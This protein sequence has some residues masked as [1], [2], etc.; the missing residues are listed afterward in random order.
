MRWR[1]WPRTQKGWGILGIWCAL[2]LWKGLIAKDGARTGSFAGDL[3]ASL[4]AIGIVYLLI[5]ACESLYF[6]VRAR[7]RG[8]DPGIRP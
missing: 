3:L 5:L 6:I 8:G 2:C 4:V 7:K 1:P